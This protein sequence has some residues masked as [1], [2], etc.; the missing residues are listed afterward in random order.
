[1]EASLRLD[2]RERF[3]IGPLLGLGKA[4]Q[5][6]EGIATARFQPTVI[7]PHGFGGRV[8]RTF[9]G[10]VEL[11]EEVTHRIGQDR[12]IVLDHQ[13]VVGAPIPDRLGN[14]RLG[15]H[16]IDGDDDPFQ[17]QTGQQFRN[18]RLLVRL[19]RR[20]PLSQHQTGAGG[21]GTDQMEWRRIHLDRAAAGLAID[22]HH[23]S[24]PSTGRIDPTQRRKAASNSSGLS[25]PN[26][27]PNVSCEGMPFSRRSQSSFSFAHSSIST[28]VSAPTSTALTATTSNSTRPCSTLLACL[29]SVID[30]NTSA[31]HSLLSAS[32]R[33]PKRQK[34]TQINPL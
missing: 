18:R 23:R 27:R 25:R 24:V 3:E 13:Q 19:L 33:H 15:T 22:D 16:R 14:I 4:R 2:H 7:L 29:G 34:T 28:K 20:R 12:L 32:M 1:M 6:V 8:R 9:L 30:T 26:K 21:K 11:D 31:R 5:W 17:R 10:G